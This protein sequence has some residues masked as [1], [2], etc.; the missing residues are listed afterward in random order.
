V[1]TAVAD[2]LD[3]ESSWLKAGRGKMVLELKP[4]VAWD[5]GS[6]VLWLLE[7]LGLKDRGD[8]FA[9]YIGDDTTDEDAFRVM[10]VC[11]HAH[12]RVC[13]RVR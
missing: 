5:K 7:A 2:V 3:K 13:C 12:M 11:A 1:E 10:Q 6:S 8:V 9:L 4:N